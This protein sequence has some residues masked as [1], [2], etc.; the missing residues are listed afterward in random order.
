M[1]Q[2]IIAFFIDLSNLW[3]ELI[4]P[5]RVKTIQFKTEFNNDMS[6]LIHLIQVEQWLI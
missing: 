5:I 1:G 3:Y 4:R 2:Q 6:I